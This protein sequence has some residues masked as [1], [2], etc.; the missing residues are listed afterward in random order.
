MNDASFKCALYQIGDR[1]VDQA[2]FMI[3]NEYNN[4]FF[5]CNYC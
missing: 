4:F 5:F 1:A 2:L 3:A